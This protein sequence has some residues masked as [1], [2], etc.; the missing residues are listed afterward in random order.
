MKPGPSGQVL[1]PG[2]S[3]HASANGTP[4]SR[5]NARRWLDDAR[6]LVELAVSTILPIKALG[7]AS[8]GTLGVGL[9]ETVARI[10]KWPRAPGEVKLY[11]HLGKTSVANIFKSPE[12]ACG[13]ATANIT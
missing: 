9:R 6:A 1:P 12:R 5:N 13:T 4:A 11:V 7:R 10:L 8:P 2:G 3:V